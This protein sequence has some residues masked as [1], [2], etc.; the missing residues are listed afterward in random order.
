MKRRSKAKM[1]VEGP[2]FFEHQKKQQQAHGE[3]QTPE[4]AKP[5]KKWMFESMF[6]PH[7]EQAAGP[8]PSPTPSRR[9]EDRLRPG[10]QGP[11]FRRPDPERWFKVADIWNRVG[12]TISMHGNQPFIVDYLTRPTY[13]ATQAERE[14]Q[15][16][17]E[18]AQLFG[19]PPTDFQGLS[20]EQ[21][22]KDVIGPFFDGLEQ[23]I[24]SAQVKPFGIPGA[25][26][27]EL[28]DS[29]ALMMVYRDR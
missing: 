9:L 16:A 26:R 23:G 20:M 24:N 1:G 4:G 7:H 28:D 5:R 29:G 8:N 11:S 10:Y 6:A 21:A 18:I 17:G 13:G 14:I 3:G 22:W 19:L 27:F 15:A 2:S 12:Y 25:I